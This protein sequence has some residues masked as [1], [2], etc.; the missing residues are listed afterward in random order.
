MSL[1]I[2][3]FKNSLLNGGVRPNLFRVNGNIGNTTA[4]SELGFLVRTAALPETTLGQ[5]EVP[6]RGRKLKL[7][8]SRE[9]A[10]WTITV[11]ADGEFK[12]RNAFERWVDDIYSAVGNVASDEHDLSGAL[13]PT[14]GVDQLN[15]KGEP[16]KSYQFFYCFPSSVGQMELDAENEDLATFEVTL[17]Y[18][19]FLTNDGTDETTNLGVAPLPGDS[20]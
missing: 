18:S 5:I 20:Q 12:I 7:P 10:E 1:N 4:P 3:Q 11:I 19:Y 8:G 16:I 17:Q 13:F 14:W 15:R 6:F 9:Y 2:N